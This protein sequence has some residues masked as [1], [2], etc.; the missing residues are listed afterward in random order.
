MISLKRPLGLLL[1]AGLAC[2]AS[3]AE[4]QMVPQIVTIPVSGVPAPPA[5]LKIACMSNGTSGMPATQCPVVKLQGN[6]IFAFS[7]IDN[8]VA[9][10]LVSYDASNHVVGNITKDGARYVWQITDTKDRTL[11]FTGQSNQTV[12]AKWAELTPPPVIVNL[13]ASSAPT[14]PPGLKVACMTNGSSLQP[15]PTCPAVKYAGM[16]TWF[17]S[18]MDNRVSLAFTTYGPAGNLVRTLEKPGTR[19]V[20]QVTS[21]PANTT[22]TAT[23]QSNTSVSEPWSGFEP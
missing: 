5:G 12:S 19:Y 16:T 15:G 20:W 10:A 7:F 18:Y 23:G 13:P 22:I 9:M 21:N 11:V 2:L 3:A 17:Y 14:P 1:A 4:A 8:R 6:H